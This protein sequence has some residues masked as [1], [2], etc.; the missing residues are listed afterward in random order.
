MNKKTKWFQQFI[1]KILVFL[2]IFTTIPLSQLHDT[3][4]IESEENV[5]EIFDLIP[6]EIEQ[7]EDNDLSNQDEPILESDAEEVEAV[8][9]QRE[10]ILE[11]ELEEEL[12]IT[13]PE[14]HKSSYE[15][16]NR[17]EDVSLRTE[18]SKVYE[19]TDGTYTAE[20]MLEPI[21]FLEG[22]EWIEFDN[23]LVSSSDG[24]HYENK[25][26]EFKAK[27]PKESKVRN[28]SNLFTYTV[29]GHE[30]KFELIDETIDR[31]RKV[32]N[33][34]QDSK[35]KRKGNTI[36][37]NTPYSGVDIEYVVDGTKVKE[38]I[39]LHSYQGRNI[40]KFNIKTSNKLQAVKQEDGSIHFLD[41][42][43]N[44]LFFIQRP[45]MFDSNFEQDPSGVLSQDVVQDIEQTK[46]GFILTLTADE[47]FLK[48]PER[49]Y[50]VTIDPWVDV[51]QP[52]DTYIASNS[53]NTN[54][55]NNTVMFVGN[56]S[57]QGVTRSL[58]KWNLPNLPNATVVSAK[59]GLRQS[60]TGEDV[61]VQ[62]HRLT[63][64]FDP[65]TVTWNTRPTFA[66][67]AAGRGN[68][69]QISEYLYIPVNN[70][71]NNW[72][73]GTTE[74]HGVLLKYSNDH[75]TT[76][77]RKGFRTTEWN[78]P[79]GT[80]IG[81][82][83]LVIDFRP[84]LLLGI[85]DY[86]TYTPDIFQGE[87]T[88]VVNVINGNLVYDI[89]LLSLPGKTAAFNLNLNYN[90]LSGIEQAYGRGWFLDA[91]QFLFINSGQSVIEYRDAQA[92]RYHFTKTVEDDENSY[93]SPEGTFFELE[94]IGTGFKLTNPD[95]TVLYFDSR[96]RNTRTVDEK[97]NTILYEFDGT[98]RRI[99]KISER[100]GNE[101]SGRDITLQYNSNGLLE[102]IRDF[103]GTETLLSYNF[104]NDKYRL[105]SITYA[106]N[107]STSLKKRISFS[108][109]NDH[110]LT[111]VI[112]A[113][114]NKGTINYDEDSRVIEVIDPRSTNTSYRLEY[115]IRETIV[116]DARGF[117]T[118]FKYSNIN[119]P[120][121]NV[122]EITDDYQGTSPSTT[123]YTW[124]KNNIIEVIE[125]DPT[126][127]QADSP[128]IY[129]GQYDDKG[130]LVSVSAPNNLLVQNEYDD[131]SNLI[132]EHEI[133]GSFAEY[134]YDDE[135]NLIS[136]TDNFNLTDF[137]SY[138][139]FGNIITSTSQKGI[140][141]NRLV[142][143]NFEVFSNDL[144]GN[145]NRALEGIYLSSATS[146]YGNRSAAIT[147]SPSETSGFYTQ[148]FAVLPEE[149][150]KNYVVSGY[151]EA[152]GIT[153]E[154]ARIR[155]YPLD[156]S[157]KHLQKDGKNI[158]YVTPAF[159]DAVWMRVSDFFTLPKETAQV[160]VDLLFT[161]TGTVR[162]DAVQVVHGVSLEE[163]YSNENPSFESGTTSW[164]FNSLGSGDGRSTERARS[165]NASFKITGSTSAQRHVGQVV[166]ASGR[167]GDPLSFSGW[168]YSTGANQTG[169]FA[170]SVVVV[171]RDGTE[172][173]FSYPFN[174]AVKNEWQFIK[175]T[176]FPNKDFQQVRL[177]ALYRNQTGIVYFDNLKLEETAST[178][179]QQ[180]SNDGN[181][182]VSE[183]NA[184]NK[185]TSFTY[186]PNGNQ[187]SSTDPLGRKTSYEYDFLDQLKKI[188]L[189][190]GSASSPDNISVLYDYDNQGNLT[191]R[192]D[193]RGHVTIFE[194]NQV[195]TVTSEIDPLGKFI[196][197]DYDQNG[198]QTSV[199]RGKGTTV[200]SKEEFTYD[201][202]NR[203]SEKWVNG[204]KVWTNQYDRAD[205]LT[206]LILPDQSSYSFT[207]DESSRLVEFLEPSGYKLANT[208]EENI[209]STS[210]GLRTSYQE[211]DIRGTAQTTS[212]NYDM[213]KRTSSITGP[214]G[215]VTEFY[216][217]E[218]SLP[219]RIKSG[220]TN[221]YQKFDGA[222][223]LIEQNILLRTSTLRLAYSYNDSGDVTSYYD[224]SA[225]HGYTYDFAGRLAT[226]NYQG[227]SARYT[228]DKAGNLLNPNGKT[229]EFNA[230]NEVVGFSYDD[231]GNLLKDD[232]YIY[233]W[234]G[235]GRLVSL[236]NLNGQLLE[237]YAY[238]PNG[239]RK[240]KTNNSGLTL[241]YHYDGTDLIRITN[242]S[243]HTVWTFTWNN[244]EPISLTNST[245]TTFYYVTNRRG[246]VVR[247]VDASGNVV[248]RYNH[249]PW[250]RVLTTSE[251]T[252]VAGQPIGYA[253]YVYDRETALYYLQARYYDPTMA[254][255]IS[256][257][258][259]IGSEN[260]PFSQNMYNYAMNNPVMLTDPDGNLPFFV[261][262]AVHI[263][264]RMAIRYMAR[265]GAQ[266]VVKSIVRKAVN[267]VKTIRNKVVGNS[268]V[269]RHIKSTGPLNH[270]TNI[271][272][273]FE[274]S[275]GKSKFWVHP[276]ATKH[277]AEYSRSRSFSHGRAMSEQA[278]LTSFRAAVRQAQKQGI[279]Y[280]K[281]MK[282]GGWE[283]IFSPARNAGQLR[284][285]KHALYK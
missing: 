52:S 251:N 148:T 118:Q 133:N 240:S 187:L 192:T 16:G 279:K 66:S 119:R 70:L 160:R 120:T 247:I 94:K 91:Q 268:G 165:G 228:Y 43:D 161:G 183:R 105:Q 158:E 13:E 277:M 87:G 174:P 107:R 258:P 131:K 42:T 222:G 260:H 236:S 60:S 103:R 239:L 41:E 234:D 20:V 51:F 196:K 283:L 44:F 56:H 110:R 6:E 25:R 141:H 180:Y 111:E 92:T 272:K 81:K 100:Y 143:S 202:K 79:D 149:E 108:Y 257:D 36:K 166:Q 24:Q 270:G 125:P 34:P 23:T 231:A 256:R 217:D 181:F 127:G 139:K 190:N 89:P 39:I 35:S 134:V 135:S 88:G 30:I 146:K 53:P 10:A 8:D 38:N 208:F 245:G 198:N 264:V 27:F 102:R 164:T 1:I 7:N 29:K 80:N 129:T 18:T 262:F 188:T 63:S 189:E 212:F 32:H 243:G 266:K 218:S 182:L 5:D 113:N 136:T 104:L 28:N 153:G 186:D 116:T 226:W 137:S 128:S 77:S 211:T 224:G 19:N 176:V 73:N 246:D 33:K 50:P 150:E 49:V 252:V 206:R 232:K 71:V 269:W 14:N 74:N 263:G 265:K 213:L 215:G 40:F 65:T 121:V 155:L 55:S 221:Q 124:E 154:G 163:Y 253:G 68:S 132:K 145:W 204:S 157:G 261:V 37:Y 173:T 11:Q 67:G 99:T 64:P 22:E 175:H 178:V 230:S 282:V 156:A 98:S 96:G 214:R 162:F 54:Y 249:D 115:F 169:A 179:F 276:N 106:N 26:N 142:N 61:P 2:L 47:S 12:P 75:E 152:S 254:R 84:N 194:Y 185:Q 82:P 57:T 21:H 140:A 112:D 58:L 126:T 259:Q 3:F 69:T 117:K 216:Y 191:K 15:D 229:Y 184:L 95:E 168:A 225:G 201:R 281:M 123:K 45:F 197:Y 130:N 273:S 200:A 227:L 248:A 114:G 59:I 48:D 46:N 167:K 62:A 235:E 210:H 280:E 72:Y 223:Q 220:V 78:N 76:I 93:T 171:N 90:S 4:A 205:N 244:G 83:K 159:S 267:K 209:A 250:G 172:E 101:T 138:D 151:I 274:L 31:G 278:M 85:T 233:K 275:M 271:P 237:S 147:L 284:V 255:F 9:P 170:L 195:N 238:H 203:L 241:N 219:I 122:T 109:N 193:P 177:L 17:K 97:G 199:E 207:Y 242:T 285:I 144:P 86:W